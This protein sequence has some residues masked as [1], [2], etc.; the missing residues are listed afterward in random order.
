VGKDVRP[1]R[2]RCVFL[3]NRWLHTAHT[4]LALLTQDLPS[5]SRPALGPWLAKWSVPALAAR[6]RRPAADPT[7][8]PPGF[9][10]SGRKGAVEFCSNTTNVDRAIDAVAKMTAAI[11][12]EEFGGVVKACVWALDSKP[13]RDLSH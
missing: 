2:Y 13:P 5:R 3:F 6:N 1:G 8:L 10:N 11:T 9:D 4:A 12:K 7:S